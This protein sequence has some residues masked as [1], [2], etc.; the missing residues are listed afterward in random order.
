MVLTGPRL[1]FVSSTATGHHQSGFKT[2]CTMQT[3]SSR[4]QQAIYTKTIS[5]R[6]VPTGPHLDFVSSTATRPH[7]S[8]FKTC[9]T[10]QT[11]SSRNQ[12]RHKIPVEICRPGRCS[13]A[14]NGNVALVWA[15]NGRRRCGKLG[16]RENVCPPSYLPSASD[17]WWSTL[18]EIEEKTPARSRGYKIIG[19]YGSEPTVCAQGRATTTFSHRSNDEEIRRHLFPSNL[20]A[21]NP[22]SLTSDRDDG[23]ARMICPK[24]QIKDY[25]IN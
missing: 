6:M 15:C 17:R 18:D 1:D 13:R 7:Q 2:Y 11:S 16:V 24:R 4:N 23:R 25:S 21:R 9:C 22:S 14:G 5:M 8:G 20:R 12:A 19:L 10:M 3:S